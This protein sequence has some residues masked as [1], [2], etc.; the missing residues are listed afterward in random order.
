M[1][2]MDKCVNQYLYRY[3]EI[4]FSLACFCRKNSAIDIYVDISMDFLIS[5]LSRKILEFSIST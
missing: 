3:I 4:K 1:I 5:I 2:D